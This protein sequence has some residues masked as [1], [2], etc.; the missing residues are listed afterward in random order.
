MPAGG[1]LGVDPF[2][3]RRARSQLSRAKPPSSRGCS[4]GLE[5]TARD[6]ARDLDRDGG[7]PPRGSLWNAST[8]NGNARRGHGIIPKSIYVGRLVWHHVRMLKD[9]ETGRPVSRDRRRP[10]PGRIGVTRG[11]GGGT[12]TPDTRIMIPLL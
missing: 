7:S 11:S 2:L 3:G 6:I 5:P 12:R 10:I 9:P 8:I 4:V 1:R